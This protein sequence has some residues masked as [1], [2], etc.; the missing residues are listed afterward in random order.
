MIMLYA[1]AARSHFRVI[2]A[3]THFH[4]ISLI[5]R[6]VCRTALPHPPPQHSDRFGPGPEEPE[7]RSPGLLN[8][9]IGRNIT[10]IAAPSHQP[11]VDFCFPFSVFCVFQFAF[12]QIVCCLHA[13]FVDIRIFLLV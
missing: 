3:R 9:I 7:C 13:I 12:H 4:I 2:W 11:I 6:H 10:I 1:M 8:I 5:S